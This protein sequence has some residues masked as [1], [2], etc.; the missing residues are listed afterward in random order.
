MDT[1]SLGSFVIAIVTPL[2]ISAIRMPASKL[3]E[4]TKRL[5]YWKEYFDVAAFAEAPIEVETRSFALRSLPKQ[6]MRPGI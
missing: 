1:S 5:Q 2:A 3:E 4:R 6:T